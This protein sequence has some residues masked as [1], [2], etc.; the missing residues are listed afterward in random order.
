MKI[1]D[2]E[3]DSYTEDTELSQKKDRLA[4]KDEELLRKRD[5]L[6]RKNRDKKT[7]KDRK[8]RRKQKTRGYYV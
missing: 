6:V 8:Q 1:R 2:L 3:V 4:M 7:T 5:K